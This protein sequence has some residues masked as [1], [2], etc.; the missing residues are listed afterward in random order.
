VEPYA[1]SR[2][3]L[4][5]HTLVACLEAE[6]NIAGNDDGD[7]VRHGRAGDEQS[8]C[9]FRKPE[10]VSHPPG[11]LPFHFDRDLIAAS[12]VDVQSR[13]QHFR[14]HPGR[15]A[16]AI[17]PAHEARMHIARSERQDGIHELSVDLSQ[18]RR[19][20]GNRGLKPVPHALRDGLPHRPLAYVLDVID[21]VVQHLVGLDSKLFPILWIEGLRIAPGKGLTYWLAFTLLNLRH[22]SPVQT[23]TTVRP[24]QCM[25][26]QAQ[27]R[28]T[29]AAT[30]IAVRSLEN[31][32]I[33]RCLRKSDCSTVVRGTP[34]PSFGSNTTRRAGWFI[35]TF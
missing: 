34:K 8:R 18:R 11:N 19:S 5:V 3:T 9:T 22:S 28:P 21:D 2:F 35:R 27:A 13:G 31:P 6:C 26:F 24:A 4:V 15:C 7:K 33:L 14:Q 30:E 23:H 32:E 29:V 12:G 25:Q 10:N 1:V 16:A 20:G 17:H